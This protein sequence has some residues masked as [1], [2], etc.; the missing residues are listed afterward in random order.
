[1][2]TRFGCKPDDG[3][4]K[5]WLVEKKYAGS[6]DASAYGGCTARAFTQECSLAVFLSGLQKNSAPAQPLSECLHD[7]DQANKLTLS[8]FA[9]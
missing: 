3:F 5:Q 4:R 2:Y 8:T 6:T 9:R 1:L 7:L